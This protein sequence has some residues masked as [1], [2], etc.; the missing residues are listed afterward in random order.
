[1]IDGDS[2]E[3]EFLT[4]AVEM[5]KDI[6]GMCCEVGLRRGLGTVTIIEAVRQFCPSK[7]VISID[8]YGS[9]P[10]VGREHVGK[11]RLDY[12]NQMRDETVSEIYQRLKGVNWQFFNM[13]DEQF[14]TQ[15]SDGVQWNE[16]DTQYEIFYSMVH[17]D[18]EHYFDAIRNEVLF[19]GRRMTT[20]GIIVIDDFTEDFIKVQPVVDMMDS[21]GFVEVKRG[22]KKSIWRSL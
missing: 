11:I 12:D 4:E 17:L 16:L 14:F 2:G 8:P 6:E 5:S 21:Y 13:T 20:G 22:L 18:A 15:M 7:R 1:M 3:Y 19:F 10:Y 9:I